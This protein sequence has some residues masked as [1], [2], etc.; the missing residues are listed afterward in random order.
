MHT[1]GTAEAAP[2]EADTGEL[3]VGEGRDGS[4]L[5]L[6]VAVIN[7]AR[8]GRT[9]H[10]QAV[11]DGDELNGLGV[12]TRLL[13][14]LDPAEIAGTITVV[15]IANL[16]GFRVA[17]H[18]N[19]IDDTKLNRTYPGDPE[20]SSSDRIAHATFQPARDADLVIDLHQGSTS[21]MI[22]EARVRCGRHHRLHDECLE[23]ARVFDAGHVLDQ[24]GP[25][26]QLAR[27]AP[28]A[29]VPTIDPELGGTVGWDESSIEVGVRGV[30]RV[31]EYYGFRDGDATP[32]TQVRATGFDRYGAPVGGLV[33]LQQSLGDRV[34]IGDPLFVVLDPFGNE[35]ARVGADEAGIFWRARRLPQVA[36]GEYV[37]S[38]GTG[39]V[40]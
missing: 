31:L 30:N 16:H 37:C 10:L 38:V 11:S 1:L 15:A 18:R 28:D 29:G 26:G 2:G 24:Q 33:S 14:T 6:P 3:H 23:L 20:G 25:D 22:D 19:P 8:E 13:P 39:I 40:E 27:V 36:T 9:L 7:G 17:E 35:K 21:R 4:P 5:G 32:E 12:L 34:E